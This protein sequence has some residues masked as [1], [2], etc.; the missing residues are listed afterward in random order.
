[1]VMLHAF[2]DVSGSGIFCIAY[3]T[4]DKPISKLLVKHFLVMLRGARGRYER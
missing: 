3:G 2:W 1:M 4:I